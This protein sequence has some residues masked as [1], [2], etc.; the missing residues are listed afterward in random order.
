MSKSLSHPVKRFFLFLALLVVACQDAPTTGPDVSSPQFDISEARFDDGNPDFFF[1][2]PLAAAPSPADPEFDEGASNG[3]LVPYVRICETD[4]AES[5]A[6]CTLDVTGD[7]TGSASGLE[8]SYDRVTELYQ[9]NFGTGQLLVD[10]EYRIEVW[11]V[12]FT[13][14]TQREALLDVVF[15]D[16]HPLLAGRP[17]WLF[18]WRDIDNAPSTASCDGTEEFCL[19]NYGQTIPVKVRIEDFVFCPVSR[20]CAVQFVAAGEDANL[21]AILDESEAASSVQLFVP[22]QDGTDFAIAFE[23]CSPQEKA[24]AQGFSA[25]P[26]FGPCLK[27]VT[28]PSP[29]PITLSD[30]AT[31]SY[32]LEVDEDAIAAE[33]AGGH[34][35]LELV[36]V[37]HFSTAGSEDGS[38][39]NVEAWPEVSPSCDEP[40][41][42]GLPSTQSPSAFIALA[43]AAGRRFL[44]L[45]AP[46]PL[47]A[48]DLGGGGEGFK[49]DSFF[50]LALPT[51]F[52]YE[53]PGDGLQRGVA[54]NDFTLRAKA[55]DL[56]GNP[57]WGARVDWS[58]IDSPGGDATVST[59]PVPTGIDGI[60][61]VLVQLSA[62][63]G[64]NVFHATGLG[65][66]DDREV[67]CTVLGGVA[68]AAACNG[69]R[70]TF[71]PFHPDGSALPD[72]VQV[73][74]EGTRL[75]F[76]VF[77]CAPG[78][79]TP[80]AVDG[81]L[82]PGEWDCALTTTFPVN[83][84]GG[85][86]VDATLYWMND[87]THFHLAVSV[88][89][90]ERRNGLRIDWDN[91][92]DAPAGTL[93]GDSYPA[94]REAGD[95]VWE[96]EPG[97][98]AA[99]KFIDERCSD[100]SQ[101]GCGTDDTE[102]FGGMDTEA[103]FDNTKG[104]VTV[105]EMSHPLS[106]DD[107]CGDRQVR[108]GC[109]DLLD[110]DIDL[111]VAAPDMVG[112]FLTLR[113]G[114]G[115]QGNTQWPAFLEYLKVTIQ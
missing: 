41:S 114:S 104:G 55:T 80:T 107:V 100:S 37:H 60:S 73:I 69:P 12:A 29:T 57:V 64:D 36:G 3:A 38:I 79:G 15:A 1:S 13:T 67:G 9:V 6:G 113:L 17:R 22:G 34:D 111:S 44:S 59:S 28:P 35:Q 11:G 32:C 23:P 43:Q 48:L 72:G 30:P 53:F 83:L 110:K 27:T 16:D 115:A 94:A 95:D 90:S 66:A 26:T 103:A 4:G 2:S 56:D 109:G 39:V 91:G 24:A 74:P 21:E 19:V 71:D 20:N 65:I 97:V 63:G 88:P 93:A 68:G 92:G 85:S 86:A 101:A 31:I 89:G 42:G 99:D 81:T 87:D 52:E 96:F 40:T 58:A 62:T 78:S 25:L 77:G 49:L 105:Y 45:F 75:P 7:V 70:G 112:F 10:R 33:L 51:K 82:E 46:E 98:G 76:V 61:E 8:M 18:G 14:D 84:S 108:R 47:M 50:M 5:T 54:G 106:T 102:V